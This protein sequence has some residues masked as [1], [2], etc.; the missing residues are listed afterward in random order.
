MTGWSPHDRSREIPGHLMARISLQNLRHS[1]LDVPKG[2]DDWALKRINVEWSDGGAYALLG[3][4][5][6]GRRRCSASSPGC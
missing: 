1:Y 2:E 4:S 3:P 5:G 6:C